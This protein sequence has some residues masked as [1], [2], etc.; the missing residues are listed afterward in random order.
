MSILRKIRKLIISQNPQTGKID[1][2]GENN[3]YHKFSDEDEGLESLYV[4]QRNSLHC[5]CIGLPPGGR[6]AE[7]GQISCAECYTHCGGSKNPVPQGCQ[8]PLCRECSYYLQLPDG[9]TIPFC[10]SCHGKIVR[11][12][13]WQTTGRALLLPFIDDKE[14]KNG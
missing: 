4:E 8:K 6:C 1:N 10:K 12:Q 11:K 7:C 2:L 3:E 14:N 9:R 13:R 5:G